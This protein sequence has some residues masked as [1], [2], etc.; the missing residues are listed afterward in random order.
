MV[1]GKKI[2]LLREL[3]G[4]SQVNMSIELDIPQATYS[5]IENSSTKIDFYT[6]RHPDLL[7]ATQTVA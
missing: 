1:I 7:I 3:N 4:Y 6:L 5:R 2:R